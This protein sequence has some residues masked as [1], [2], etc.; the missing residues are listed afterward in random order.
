MFILETPTA[1]SVT[2][3]NLN[4][5][6][7]DLV[8]GSLLGDGYLMRTTCG[9]AFRV[10][11]GL[12]QI[13]YVD[14]KY[15]ILTS[16]VLTRPK[17]CGKCYYFRTVSHPCFSNLRAKFYKGRS[18]IA[19]VDLLQKRLTPFTLAVWIMDDGSKDGR[20]LRINSQSF[21]KDDNIILQ[22]LLRAKLGIS[23]SLNQDKDRFRL[24][25]RSKSMDKLLKLIKPH[26]IPSM[27]YKLPL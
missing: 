6:R 8:I 23:T 16:F 18:K 21:S 9:Y 4:E 3:Q 20:Q 19:D 5:L 26:I 24:R 2:Y 17:K 13:S 12:S 27:L 14:W 25:V 22:E 10:N 11:H 15:E 7:L 1:R